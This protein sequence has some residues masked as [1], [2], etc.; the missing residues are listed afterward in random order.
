ML[1][2]FLALAAFLALSAVSLPLENNITALNADIEA[3]S[4]DLR[5]L[6]TGVD[7]FPLTNATVA[8]ALVH[9]R[10]PISPSEN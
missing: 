1:S 10:T 6:D 3:V 7:T 8:Q 9:P 5:I 4:L 2:R